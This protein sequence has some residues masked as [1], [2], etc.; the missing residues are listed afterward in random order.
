[1]INE[2]QTHNQHKK[3]LKKH[4][5]ISSKTPIYLTRLTLTHNSS[6]L[7]MIFYSSSRQISSGNYL[8]FMRWEKLCNIPHPDVIPYKQTIFFSSL[9]LLNVNQLWVQLNII[10]RPAQD[11]T[12]DWWKKKS[13]TSC[14]GTRSKWKGERAQSRKEEWKKFMWNNEFRSLNEN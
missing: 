5:R 14:G 1:M 9:N 4:F 3:F 6:I 8:T 2:E 11:N 12:S 10:W 13:A 7:K